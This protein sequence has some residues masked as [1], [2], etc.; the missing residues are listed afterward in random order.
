MTMKYFVFAALVLLS[1]CEQ[2]DA[3]VSKVSIGHVVDAQV[4]PTSFNES[5][6]TQIKTERRFFVVYGL[7]NIEL[8][9]EAFL[10]KT[11]RGRTCVEIGEY[12]YPSR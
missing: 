6:K 2:Q 5:I 8:G 10:V 12:C 7:V 9:T 3:A 1:A 4:V 11:R